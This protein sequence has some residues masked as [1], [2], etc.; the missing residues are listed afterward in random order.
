M[1]VLCAYCVNPYVARWKRLPPAH[2]IFADEIFA[3]MPEKLRIAAG[4]EISGPI[5]VPRTRVNSSM[6]SDW[7]MSFAVSMSIFLFDRR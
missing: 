2:F 4:S 3:L 7:A 1:F 6:F 5:F